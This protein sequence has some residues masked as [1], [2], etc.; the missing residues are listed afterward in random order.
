[1]TNTCI[2]A[3]ILSSGLDA[4]LDATG[5]GCQPRPSISQSSIKSNANCVGSRSS[6]GMTLVSGSGLAISPPIGETLAFRA[7]DSATGALCVVNA[8][9]AAI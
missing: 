4:I 3:R 7:S 5:A 9:A 6:I 1:M 2:P 8:E